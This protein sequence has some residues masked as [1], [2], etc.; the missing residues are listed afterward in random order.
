[1]LMLSEYK[2][3]EVDGGDLSRYLELKVVVGISCDDFEYCA[4]KKEYGS[5]LTKSFYKMTVTDLYYLLVE[6]IL[7]KRIFQLL[8][9]EFYKKDMS[10]LIHLEGYRMFI[11]F[12]HEICRKTGGFN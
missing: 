3:I 2:L 7:T 8:V 9:L 12:P 1:M 4:F 10:L 5:M 11:I 6:I